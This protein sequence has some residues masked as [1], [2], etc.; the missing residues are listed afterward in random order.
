MFQKIG[1]EPIVFLRPLRS[2]RQITLVRKEQATNGSSFRQTRGSAGRLPRHRGRT[3]V[4]DPVWFLASSKIFSGSLDKAAS[5]RR[6][7]RRKR[8]P[9]DFFAIFAFFAAKISSAAETAAIQQVGV[10]FLR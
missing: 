6:S 3:Y 4:R 1:I 2:W 5:S 10:A 8:K 7:P 9:I